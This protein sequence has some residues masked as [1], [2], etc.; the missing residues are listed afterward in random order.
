MQTMAN[1][2]FS[3]IIGS[4]LK[5]KDKNPRF[6]LFGRFLQLYEPL[7]DQ[8]LK[9]YIDIVNNMFKTVLNFQIQETDEMVYIPTPRAIDF[10][11]LTFS[12]RLTNASLNHCLKIIR[13]KQLQITKQMQDKFLHLHTYQEAVQLDDF[14]EFVIHATN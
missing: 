5:F 2:K 7:Q 10:F 11:R 4:C 1:K 6:R 14:A 12:S 13:R 8:D 9:L 3:Q